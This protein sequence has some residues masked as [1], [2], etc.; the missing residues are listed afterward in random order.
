MVAFRPKNI[1]FPDR[2]SV[3]MLTVKSVEEL[4]ARIAQWKQQGEKIGFVPTMGNL[5]AGHLA[6]VDQAR[7][8]TDRVVVSI[9]VN[10]TQFGPNEDYDS[11]PRTLQ[12]DSELLIEHDT[13]LLF[14]PD[15]KSMYGDAPN[16]SVHVPDEMNDMLC[17]RSRQG[18]FD[19]VATVVSKL[20]NQVQP[21]IAVFGE[22]DYQQ[23]SI[24]RRMVNDLNFPL[25]I[26][27][28][29]TMREADGLAMS[30]RNGYLDE[31]QRLQAPGL[32]RALQSLC[33]QV[34]MAPQDM[35][36][37]LKNT[38][39][40]LC[41]EGFNVEYVE[42]RRQT[43]LKLPETGDKRLIVLAAVRMGHTRLI[44]NCLFE[45]E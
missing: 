28:Y 15:V 12:R 41:K 20:F 36:T 38:I 3:C 23:L 40:G 1:L 13:D 35:Q 11:Y 19:G 43:D 9:F 8:L 5:H 21:D 22:K 7:Q 26:V 18:H 2:L 27:G 16:V 34:K 30:S 37:L 25:E 42:I 29:P 4:R 33:E 32:N 10:P 45:L 24:I 31:E 14:T 44:D 39:D 6:L 17:G